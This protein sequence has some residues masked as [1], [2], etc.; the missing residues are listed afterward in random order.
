MRWRKPKKGS[1]E[2]QFRPMNLS[3]KVVAFK[4]QD[5]DEWYASV[6][7]K[8]TGTEGNFGQSHSLIW[9]SVEDYPSE[10]EARI[11]GEFHV[12]TSLA[13]LLKG[14]AERRVDFGG[15]E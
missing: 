1:F 6:Y 10:M 5:V 12:C 13:Q 9:S 3:L 15:L 4:K 7:V 14:V 2:D 11:A 8:T